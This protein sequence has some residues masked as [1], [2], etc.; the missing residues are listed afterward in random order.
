M[1]K[2]LL[3][4]YRSKTSNVKIELDLDNYV[5]KDNLK[6]LNISTSSYALKTNIA[7]LITEIDK[8]DIPKLTT[9][10]ADLGKLTKKVQEDFTKKTN[11]NTLKAK[12]DNSKT[13]NDNLETKVTSNHLTTES[14]INNLKTKV[15]NIDLTKY[16]KKTD[17]D[18]KFGNLELKIPDVSS[19]FQTTSFNSNF[20]ELEA[21]IKTAESKPDISNLTSKTEVKYVENKIPDSNAFVKKPDSS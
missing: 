18:T 10:P 21:K 5:T 2:Y 8:L 6:H 13:D 15:D 1:S 3:P 9:V 14:S 19:L 20:S 12:V 11:F 7:A 17:Y 16:V 4:P